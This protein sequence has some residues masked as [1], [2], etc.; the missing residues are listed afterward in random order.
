MTLH[1]LV[2]IKSCFYLFLS[3]FLRDCPS[4]SFSSLSLGKLI[5]VSKGFAKKS[6]IDDHFITVFRLMA[7]TDKV[8]LSLDILRMVGRAC[9]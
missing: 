2:L 3:S 6:G 8:H 4:S 7:K 1:L 5:T 9:I